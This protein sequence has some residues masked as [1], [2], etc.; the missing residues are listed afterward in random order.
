MNNVVRPHRCPSGWQHSEQARVGSLK[1]RCRG[2]RSALSFDGL[3]TRETHFLGLGFRP[4][5]DGRSL[6]P[7][8]I[9]L[10]GESTTCPRLTGKLLDV[11]AVELDV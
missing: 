7:F 11:L 10:A 2:S 9:C 3:G 8:I 4:F 6:S 5:G 1:R